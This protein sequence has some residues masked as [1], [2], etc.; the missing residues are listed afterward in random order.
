MFEFLKSPELKF[1]EAIRKKDE[2]KAIK[3]VESGKLDLNNDKMSLNALIGKPL[4]EE[5]VKPKY[6][7]TK[8]NL[9]MMLRQAVEERNIKDIKILVKNGADI[10]HK[11]EKGDTLLIRSSFLSTNSLETEICP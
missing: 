3:I 8:E 1:L 7:L 6:K 10:N 4:L 2:Q 11:N 5:V 9:N